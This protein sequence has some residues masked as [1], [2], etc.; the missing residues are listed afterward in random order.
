M[1]PTILISCLLVVSG[2]L[3]GSGHAQSDDEFTTER[4]RFLHVYGNST[5]DEATRYSNVVDLIKFYETYSSRLSLKSPFNYRAEE[6]LRWYKEEQERCE[7]VRPFPEP[8]YPMTAPSYCTLSFVKRRIVELAEEI[9]S[10]AIKS[11]RGS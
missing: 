2:C 10:E 8:G 6:H 4:Q 1:N 9:A 5:V 11:P 3:L 7:G